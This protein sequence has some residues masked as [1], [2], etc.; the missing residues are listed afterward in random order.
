MNKA[1]LKAHFFRSVQERAQVR[2]DTV[3]VAHGTVIQIEYQDGRWWGLC[4]WD[5]LKQR[6]YCDWA[7]VDGWPVPTTLD[8]A[9]DLA[10]IVASKAPKLVSYLREV[11]ARAE[12]EGA[13]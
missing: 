10:D 5:S 2:T 1:A 11:M 3:N 9:S 13:S 12:S 4:T 6:I 7:P 8:E